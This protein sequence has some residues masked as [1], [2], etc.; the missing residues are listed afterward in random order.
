MP[1][2]VPYARLSSFYLAYYAALGA[3]TPYWPL[4]LKECGQDPAAISILMSLWYA[5]RIVA[6]GV[7]NGRVARSAQ[8]I[9]WLRAGSI[10][11]VLAFAPFF[12]PL[13]FAGLF[14]A[15]V[16]FCAFYNAVMPQF[17]AITLSHLPGRSEHYG[18]IRVW[19]SI[20][21]IVVVELLGLVFDRLSVRHLPW[22]MLP[23]YVAI[24][25]SSYANDY[26]PVHY[27]GATFDPAE[28]R[29]RVRR[30]EVLAFFAVAFL[31][32]ISFGPLYT[33][34][35]LFLDQHA[36]KPSTLSALWA[37][38][39]A[40][41]IAVFFLAA[42][43]FARFDARTVLLL[44]AVTA[45]LRWAVTARFA[46]DIVLV[47]AAQLTHAINFAAFWA[48][49]MQYMARLFPGPLAGHGQSVFYGF[50]SGVGG[51]LG[52]LIA[53][54]AWRWGGGELAFMGATGFAVAAGLI[55]WLA[56]P[57]ARA[58]RFEPRAA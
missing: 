49:C 43:L 28:F 35:S 3:F 47:T 32:Q 29:R 56:L 39:V 55:V 10:A 7:W 2:D 42:R 22:L 16:V 44:A 48:A 21:F 9:R 5:T 8:P 12:L 31:M 37:I 26:G 40:V 52:A 33:Y 50:S 1:T 14:A 13:D 19:G 30:R 15:M 53:G 57:P 24:V 4:Y 23:L 34:F 20:G 17:E 38:G 36:Y 27:A 41:E 58:I 51:V 54:A 18:R 11:T 46:D 25:A 45:A 6:P